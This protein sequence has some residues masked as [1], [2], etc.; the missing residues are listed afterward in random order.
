MDAEQGG[1]DGREEGLEDGELKAVVRDVRRAPADS[2][3]DLREE[4]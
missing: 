3:N 2:I 1:G 4:V